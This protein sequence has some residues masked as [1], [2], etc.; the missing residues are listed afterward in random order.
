MDKSDAAGGTAAEGYDAFIS[1]KSEDLAHAEAL[2]QRLAAAGFR[3][4]F[5]KAR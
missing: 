5:D 2:H 1:Y 4:W 3:V